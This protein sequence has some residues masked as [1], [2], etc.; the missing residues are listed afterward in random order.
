[1]VGDIWGMDGSN[2]DHELPV[3]DDA[4]DQITNRDDAEK[5]EARQ[6]FANL[7]PRSQ[8]RQL[9]RVPRRRSPSGDT[10]L[11]LPEILEP[12]PRQLIRRRPARKQRTKMP[13]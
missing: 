4:L 7:T 1:M 9:Q 2:P 10:P 5:G 11:T 8:R 6:T 12:V 13:I 3:A